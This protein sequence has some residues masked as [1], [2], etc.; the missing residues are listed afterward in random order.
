MELQKVNS[1]YPPHGNWKTPASLPHLMV[2][3]NGL[4]FSTIYN[5]LLQGSLIGSE[6]NR[7]LSIGYK[8]SGKV[9][10]IKI[11]LFVAALFIPN[12]ENKKCVN[13]KDGNK[14]NNSAI[15]L[16]WTTHS[17]NT[18]HAV[19]T[20]LRKSSKTILGYT[21]SGIDF[22]F[23]LSMRKSGVKQKEIAKAVGVNQ[24][25]ISRLLKKVI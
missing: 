13:H 25:T 20:G 11:H 24:S 7:Y 23:V 22:Q 6:G 4:V 16:E 21:Y 1:Q 9:K 14:L 10:H 2:S 12:P 17:E 5:R 8:T 15:N 3:E 19:D 18:I